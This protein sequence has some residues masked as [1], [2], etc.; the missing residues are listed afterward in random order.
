[1]EQSPEEYWLLKVPS[2]VVDTWRGLSPD[3]ELGQIIIDQ[4]HLDDNRRPVMHLRVNPGPDKA[5]EPDWLLQTRP[6]AADSP[7]L[8]FFDSAQHPASKVRMA[9]KVDCIVD[10][11]PVD[12][13]LRLQK[14]DQ[15]PETFQTHEPRQKLVGG[16]P[17][18]AVGQTMFVPGTHKLPVTKVTRIDNTASHLKPRME[19][20]R[21]KDKRVRIDKPQ[22]QTLLFSLFEK[23]PHWSMKDLVVETEQPQRFLKEVLD[24]MAVYSTKGDNMFTWSLKPSFGA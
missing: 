21:Q 4:S 22:L 20:N 17:A 14:T 7:Q 3:A 8:V 24:E 23:K 12:L 1:M 16:T 5:L 2:Y 13:E 9:G 11:R 10:A 19:K 6:I 15:L 18:R